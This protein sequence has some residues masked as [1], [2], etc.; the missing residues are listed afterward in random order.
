M[1]ITFG[2]VYRKFTCH[3]VV[4]CQPGYS[5]PSAGSSHSYSQPHGHLV[6]RVCSGHDA[7]AQTSSSHG[8]VGRLSHS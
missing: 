5:S 4:K 7:K 6:H 3:D 1:Y 2:D 8:S